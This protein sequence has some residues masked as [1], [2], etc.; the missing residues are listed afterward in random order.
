M[1]NT[2][3]AYSRKTFLA[4]ESIH[5]MSAIHCKIYDDGK[6]IIRIS[7]CHNSMRLWNFITEQ[8]GKKEMLDK[9]YMLK[10]ELI[11]FETQIKATIN[12][13]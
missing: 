12:E 8:E 1:S 9:I 3:K 11:A 7:D 4:P 10:Q 2:I 5:S 6:A 13:K